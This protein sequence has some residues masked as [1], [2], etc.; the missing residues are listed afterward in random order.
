[1]SNTYF[2]VT[3]EKKWHTQD[4]FQSLKDLSPGQFLGGS[5]SCRYH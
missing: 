2:K 4:F 1:M 3:F 5:K